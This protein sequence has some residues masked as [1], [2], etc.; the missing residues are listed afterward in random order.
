M[1]VAALSISLSSMKAAS[2]VSTSIMKKTMD[3]VNENAQLMFQ[4]MR[5]M[6]LSVNPAVGSKFDM[7][8]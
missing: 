2:S 8:I 5:Q 4:S 1:D 6:E 7:R 3:V